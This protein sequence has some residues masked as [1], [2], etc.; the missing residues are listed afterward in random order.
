METFFDKLFGIEGVEDLQNF[1]DTMKRQLN[2]LKVEL[3]NHEKAIQLLC[4]S[5]FLYL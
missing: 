1:N 4:M 2:E 5:R 3:K